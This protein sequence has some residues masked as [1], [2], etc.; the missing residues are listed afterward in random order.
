MILRGLNVLVAYPFCKPAV[1]D[2]LADVHALGGRVLIDS[3]AFSAH[4]AGVVVTLKGYHT[5]L[6]SLPF[7][8]YGYFALDVIGDAERSDANYQRSLDA[9]FSPWPVYTF[10][11]PEADLE[12]LIHTAP[13]VGLGGLVAGNRGQMGQLKSYIQWVAQRVPMSKT[14]VLGVASPGL[15]RAHRPASLDS[16]YW[17]SCARFGAVRLNL[18]TGKTATVMRSTVKKRGLNATQLRALRRHGLTPGQLADDNFWRSVGGRVA[19][20][21]AESYVELAADIEARCGTHLFAAA[22]AADAVQEL[23]RASK[24]LAAATS[25]SLRAEA[26]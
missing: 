16:A 6:R 9:G 5:F 8:P 21:G 19:E 17:R 1:I 20:V 26:Q 22:G 11:A 13:R 10:G 14:H 4:N 7:A 23:I 3:G 18:G 2:A 25:D 15:A 12:R 24:R